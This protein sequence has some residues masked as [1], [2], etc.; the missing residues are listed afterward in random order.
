MDACDW[1]EKTIGWTTM[2]AA[3]NRALAPSGLRSAM[4]LEV[5]TIEWWYLL[6]IIWCCSSII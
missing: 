4:I 3:K 5:E 2:M 6:L 1:G